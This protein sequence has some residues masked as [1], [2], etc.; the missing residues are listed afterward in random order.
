MIVEGR[1]RSAFALIDFA[2][3]LGPPLDTKHVI[4]TSHVRETRVQDVGR[5]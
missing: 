2:G 5:R 3:A 1:A 4:A